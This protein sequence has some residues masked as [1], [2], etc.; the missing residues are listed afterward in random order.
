MFPGYLNA[1]TPLTA[2]GFFLTGD[3]AT[4]ER[5]KLTVFERTGDMF[6]SGGENVYPAEIERKIRCV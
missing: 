5:G 4:C 6:V 2:D 1:R 3:T